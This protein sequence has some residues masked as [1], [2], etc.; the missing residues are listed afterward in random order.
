MSS[1]SI[2]PQRNP[3]IYQNIKLFD[4][5]T[6]NNF[7]NWALKPLSLNN[8]KIKSIS[9]LISKS[10]K[11]PVYIPNDLI[12]GGSIIPNT[13]QIYTGSDERLKENIKSFY[14]NDFLTKYLQ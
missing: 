11:V 2:N 13:G 6:S 10:N 3:D 1:Q 9:P 12:V 8:Q 14:Y 7:I 5:S 4:F